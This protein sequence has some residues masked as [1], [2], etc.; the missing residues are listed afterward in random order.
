MRSGSPGS[1]NDQGFISVAVA[2]L[3]GTFH[4]FYVGFG[5]WEDHVTYR[6]SLHQFLGMAT[7]SNGVD[8]NR[9]DEIVPVNQTEKGEVGSVA[10]WRVGSRIHLWISDVW[11]GE[12]GVGYFLFDPDRGTGDTGG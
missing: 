12:S 9:H 7:S 3:D 4:M 5:D 10:A 11:D 1:W 6:S 8:W 2:F